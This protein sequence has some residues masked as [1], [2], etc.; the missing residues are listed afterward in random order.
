[1]VGG[2]FP[3]GSV[4]IVCIQN[5]APSRIGK[6]PLLASVQGSLDLPIAA[7]QMRRFFHP[8]GGPARQDVHAAAVCDAGS[9]EGDLSY[10]A[11]AA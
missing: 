4:S 2:S 9:E 6:P 1:M 11:W 10:E 3:D 8:C 7:G 5:A